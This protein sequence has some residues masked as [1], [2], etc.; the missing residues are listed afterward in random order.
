MM[1]VVLA[2]ALGAGASEAG[3]ASLYPEAGVTQVNLNGGYRPAGAG[4]VLL[5]GSKILVGPKG[6]AMLVYSP[7][8]RVR[9]GSGLWNV[10]DK[11]P[12]GAGIETLDFASRMNQAGPDAQN[13]ELPPDVSAEG[14][15]AVEAGGIDTTT[16]VIGGLVVGGAVAAAIALSQGG[17]SDKPASP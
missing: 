2:A 1:G 9:L 16:L 11:A 6:A 13:T 15:S 4:T 17:G 5:P 3:A 12:C 10:L 14:G 7:T 8:C